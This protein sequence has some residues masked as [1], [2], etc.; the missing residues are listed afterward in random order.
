MF[1]GPD[2]PWLTVDAVPHL[3]H[4]YAQNYE[5]VILARVF[6]GKTGFYIDAG[7]NHP[8]FHSVT[9]HFYD[10]GWSGV[11]IEPHLGFHQALC[12]Q[13][14]WDVNL[15]VG[16]SDREAIVTF[17][18]VASGMGVNSLTTHFADWNVGQEVRARDVQITTLAKICEAHAGDRQIDF[19]KIDVEGVEREACEGGDWA[20]YRP[21]VVVIELNQPAG[22]AEWDAWFLAKGYHFAYFDAINRFYV[23]DEDKALIP[24]LAVPFNWCDRAMSYEHVRIVQQLQRQV[25][26]LKAENASIRERGESVR[27]FLQRELDELK[28]LQSQPEPIL[29]IPSPTLVQGVKRRLGPPLPPLDLEGQATPR[30]SRL[31]SKTQDQAVL[32]CR[33]GRVQ[34]APP[35][36]N[37]G[38]R[39]TRPTIY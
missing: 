9:K 26:E 10:K 16:V 17:H 18:E 24:I 12:E 2:G 31:K 4:S 1:D 6:P 27:Q 13:R 21:R 35:R 5:D 38:A 29:S 30:P 32:K 20:K 14:P 22:F 36:R 25:A 39:C 11:N 7:A 15:C 37:G 8:E 33:V 23:R 34:R 3:L 19:L 28:V